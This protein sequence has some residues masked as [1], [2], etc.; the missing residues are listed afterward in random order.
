MLKRTICIGDSQSKTKISNLAIGFFKWLLLCLFALLFP[1][2]K[3][4]AQGYLD[5]ATILNDDESF[6]YNVNDFKVV[7]GY[8]YLMV[9]SYYNDPTD[10]R[11]PIINGEVSINIDGFDAETYFAIFDPNCNQIKGT[12]ISAEDGSLISQDLMVDA[13][14]NAYVLSMA[15]FA[16][17]VMT[18]DGTAITGS[19]DYILH[20]Y[21]P[22]GTLVYATVYG[23]TSGS[24]ESYVTSDGTN[25]YVIGT[26]DAGDFS[27]T[28]G[29]THTG[30]D[31]QFLVKY[32]A[33]GNLVYATIMGGSGDDNIIS[34]NAVNGCAIVTGATSSA[35]FP[36][37][38]GTSFQGGTNDIT[39]TKYDALGNI[40]FSNI[41]G[42]SGSDHIFSGEAH[43][44]TDGTYIYLAGS[45]DSADFPTTDGTINTGGYDV[46]VRKYDLQGNL[47]FSTLIGSSANDYPDDIVVQGGE[48]YVSGEYRNSDFPV[49]TGT[50]EDDGAFV[51]KL[52]ANGATAYATTYGTF[53]NIGSNL[54][55]IYVDAGGSVYLPVAGNVSVATDN[56]QLSTEG[57]FVGKF[58][59]DGTLCSSNFITSAG[60]RN[61]NTC[62]SMVGDTLYIVTSSYYNAAPAGISTD[63]TVYTTATNQDFVVN[64]FVF[65]PTPDPITID[66]LSTN[67]ITVCENGIIDKIEGMEQVI[68][69]SQFPQIYLDGVLSDQA[70]IPLVYQWQ[71]STTG[72]YPWTDIPGALAQ[73][74]DYTPGPTTIDLYYRRQ[75]KT[76]ECCG[77][78]IV[79]TSDSVHIQ[80]TSNVAPMVDA[81][82]V[83]YT[84][85]DSSVMINATI[86]GGTAPFTYN[87]NDGAY[88][89]E[90]PIVSPS[91]SSVYTLEVTDANGCIQSGQTTIITY[92]ADAG[93]DSDVCDGVGTTIGGA[94]LSGVTIVPSG[95]TPPAGEHSIEYSWSPS[96]G[97][98]CTDCPNP[99]A[100]P[101]SA[102]T[103]TLTTTI[104]YPDGGSCQTSDM[105]N[106]DVIV[107]PPTTE[108][109]GMDTVLCFGESALLGTA[110]DGVAGPYLAQQTGSS[111]TSGTLTVSQLSDGNTSTGIKTSDGTTQQVI[112]NLGSVNTVNILNIAINNSSQ[113]FD[114]DFSIEVSSDGVNYTTLFNDVRT[115]SFA[116]TTVSA[117]ST[118]TLTFPEQDVQYFRFTSES[119]FR[120][121]GIG[122][123][124]AGFQSYSY[125]WT[126]GVYITTDGSYATYDAG[127][128]EMP[129]INP[130]TYTVTAN[131][132]TCNFYDQVTVAVIEARA[133]EDGCGPRFLGKEDR[134]PN[135]EET[136][137]WTKITDPAITTGTGDF[138]GATDILFAPVSA[139]TGGVV[140]Y[141]LTVSY[142]LPSGVTGVCRDTVIVPDCGLDGCD[143]VS[144]DGGCPD[145]DD[146]NPRLIGIPPNNDDPSLWTYSW[147]SNLGMTG[148]DNYNSQV[149]T[150]TDN[151]NRTYT[152]TFTSVIDPTYTCTDMIE[153]NSTVYSVPIID[154][155]GGTVCKGDSINIGDGSFNSGLTYEWTNGQFLDDPTSNYPKASPPSTTEFILTAT[156][157][158]TGCQAFDTITVI[159]PRAA[160]AGQDLIVCDNGVVTIGANTDTLGFTYS[161]EPAGAAWEPSSGPTDA[162][163]E[164]FV[165]TTQDFYLTAVDTSGLCTTRDTVTVTV[166]S[167]PPSFTLPDIDFCPSQT[168]ALVL[169]TND[170]TN[171]GDTLVPDG[172]LYNWEP[173]TVN[174]SSSQAPTIN[175]SL[176][177]V[178]TTYT[179][180]VATPGG[181]NQKAAQTMVPIMNPPL[182]GSNGTMCLGDSR[183]IGDDNNEAGFDYVWTSSDTDVSATLDNAMALNPSFTPDAAGTFTFI[184]TKTSTPLS[185]SSTAEVTIN[186]TDLVAPTL[187]PQTIC[188]GEVVQIGAAN[189]NTLQYQWEPTTGLDDAFI[190]NPTFLGT[191]STNYT[192]TVVNNNGCI[193]EVSTSVTVNPAPAVT[194]TIPDTVLCDVNTSNL[195]L[196]PTITPAGNY[197]YSWSP[198]DNL[199]NPSILNPTFFVSGEGSYNYV[200]S[201]VDQATGCTIKDTLDIVIEFFNPRP[202]I[203]SSTDTVCAN[204]DNAMLSASVS[205]SSV[206]YQWQ[207]STTDCTTGFSDLVGE[208]SA[209]LTTTI[210]QETYFRVIVTDANGE[211]RD[212]SDCVKV[213]TKVCITNADLS[214]AKIVN[215]PMPN[216]GD[217]VTFNITV[218]NAGPLD[219][220]GIEVKDYLPVG[221]SNIHNISGTGTQVIDTLTWSNLSIVNG[222]S[223]R[224]TFDAVV[225]APTGTAREYDNVAEITASDQTDPDSSPDNGVDPDMDGL[226]GTVDTGSNDGSVDTDSDDDSDNEPVIVCTYTITARDTSICAGQPIDLSTLVEGT[227][228]GTLAYGT[229]FSYGGTNMISPLVTTTYYV[230][231]SN[232]TNMCVDTA[233][234]LV[235]V[236]SC[237]WGDLPDVSAMTGAGDYQTQDANSGPVHVIDP[238]ITLGSTIDAETDG[239]QSTNALGDDTDED[240]LII[241]ESLDLTPG[242]TFRLPLNY[243]NATGNPAHIE[244]WIDWNNNGEFDAG[245]M[246]LDVTDPS[247][248]LYDLLEVTVPSDA[249]TGA[250][251]GLR[252]RI[253]NQ[254]NMTPYGLI[255]EGEVEDYLI[256]I[257]CSKQI[258]VPIKI[259]VLRK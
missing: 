229:D 128:L 181:C 31:D 67:L 117:T 127:S 43:V 182:V 138:V 17:P 87:W 64:K 85:P 164:V 137:A 256:G 153:A 60:N 130:V 120:D 3:T 211:C 119:S 124:S 48:V 146:G 215:N 180:I 154:A 228:Q 95:G 80:V 88:T 219:A 93:L 49:T 142:T 103:Y 72:S 202:T 9:S 185:C 186:V 6:T 104:Y 204:Q 84:C 92:E 50:T 234:I 203:M 1:L 115:S 69:G 140:G 232:T 27:S 238:A 59:P 148:L 243:T 163:P 240:G 259:T 61:F 139:S 209:S 251:L 58:N 35:D 99:T 241:F 222:G 76:S 144:L 51:W 2:S 225:N 52:A 143:V 78:T 71:V 258:C 97:L 133:G 62:P 4:Q 47:I 26:I 175:T 91:I 218:A 224:L 149:V 108:F 165:A 24:Y 22:D 206:I 166:E 75:T 246:I 30:S 255:S 102:A 236:D 77:G 44:E 227:A 32:D 40:A 214:L 123:F 205:E 141:E 230:R 37:T 33:T 226:I 132:G 248:G 237:D 179:V 57:L 160:N 29:T 107:A 216:V 86:V 73:Q 210:S 12:Y 70:D 112:L 15:E 90:D 53:S 45:T 56:E 74:K 79:S 198:S 36:S 55:G 162:I 101:A 94:A 161:W 147:D 254:D 252:I 34:V 145:F 125:I 223:I 105:V 159:V 38:D 176:P 213:S 11:F 187:T 177:T 171:T 208:K 68:D 46:Y 21:A 217:T 195:V 131:Q 242:S 98:S 39:I 157:N 247:S 23:N 249:V 253:S 7:N 188:A 134:T 152:V 169:G 122:E 231:D 196:N 110:P 189:D 41:Y 250:Y 151:T 220:T 54:S 158:I 194:V 89:V 10:A 113:S 257:E 233:L 111:T 96:T 156:D 135:I 212:T 18:T 192:L 82:A 235:Q 173:N 136:Y 245:E 66:T 63:G 28:D 178:P 118:T 170:G 83:C 197:A 121:V 199:S 190:A 167:L 168:E 16:G 221:Y 183:L 193:A 65:C 116:Q 207:S 150:L 239:Q 42:G 20:K 129:D 201:I 191:T 14:G 8:T 106:V 25:A 200:L 126:P 172:Y 19:G 174:T 5:C 155:V 100:T 114:S 13:V 184:V 109:A 81:G 244:A